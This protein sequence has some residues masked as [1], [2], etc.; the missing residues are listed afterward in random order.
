[1]KRL[2]IALVLAASFP[3]LASVSCYNN[4]NGITTCSG[5]NE[6]GQQVYTTTYDN[7]NGL[8]TTTG[9]VGDKRVDVSCFDNGHGLTTCN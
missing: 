7:G 9:N 2:L 3:A 5:T 4:G 8:K 1:M 6:A